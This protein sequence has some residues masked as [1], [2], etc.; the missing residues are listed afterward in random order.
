MLLS[1]FVDRFFIS[2]LLTPGSSLAFF[3][4]FFFVFHSG[5]DYVTCFLQLSVFFYCFSSLGL[6]QCSNIPKWDL[7]YDFALLFWFL[8]GL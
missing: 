4:L 1:Y 6:G 8:S 3:F 7:N 5:S 2:L